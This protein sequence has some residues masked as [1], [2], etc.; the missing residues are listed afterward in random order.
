[1]F[2]FSWHIA[3]GSISEPPR[4][5]R[6]LPPFSVSAYKNKNCFTVFTKKQFMQVHVFTLATLLN[7][8]L[9]LSL[10]GQCRQ[11]HS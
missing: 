3:K 11:Q 5:A 10:G 6:M 2:Q 1:M 4:I 7:K 9:S 8:F